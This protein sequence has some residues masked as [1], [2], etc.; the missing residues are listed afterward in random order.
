MTQTS[1]DEK[2][3]GNEAD[4]RRE[5]VPPA[6]RALDEEV[7][8]PAGGRSASDY[9]AMFSALSHPLRLAALYTLYEDG[10]CTHGDL[11]DALDVDGNGLNHHL[12]AVVDTPLVRKT[13][14]DE[15]GRKMIYHLTPVGTRVTE[16]VLDMMAAEREAIETEYL[17]SDRDS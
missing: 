10:G 14:S 12:N 16:Y 2:A 1:P 9:A 5:D 17:D 13:P 3:P 4:G 8:H 6:L 11:A 15:D 7:L